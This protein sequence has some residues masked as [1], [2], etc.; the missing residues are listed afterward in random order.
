MMVDDHWRAHP[1]KG[2]FPAT[3]CPFRADE[4]IDEEGLR[5]YIGELASAEGVKGLTCN[6]HTGEV[7]LEGAKEAQRQVEPLNRIVYAFGEPGSGAHQ[8]MKC[9]RWLLGKFPSPK[10]RRPLRDL[11]PERIEEMRKGLE[12]LGYRC[13]PK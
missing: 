2:V 12:K 8:R 1:W 9:S 4:S 6:G 7:M 3:L 11:G 10:M 13:V 5:A